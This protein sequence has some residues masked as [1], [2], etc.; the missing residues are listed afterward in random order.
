M[1]SRLKR[2]SVVPVALST[3]VTAVVAGVLAVPGAHASTNGL[4]IRPAMG[5]SSWSFVRRNPTAAVIT[6]QADAMKNSGLAAHG[7]QYVNLDDFFQKCDGNGYVVDGNG[8]WTVD[9]A[10]FPGGIKPVADHVHSLGLKFGLYVTPGIPQ[11]AVTN[12]TP[13]AGTA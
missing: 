6:A 10:K 3:G 7:F 11:N 5:W 4:S 9:T 13:I 2:L 12:N 1:Q 8:R